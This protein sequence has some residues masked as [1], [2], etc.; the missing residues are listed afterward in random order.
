MKLTTAAV[1]LDQIPGNILAEVPVV[2]VKANVPLTLRIMM[3]HKFALV[4]TGD[5]PVSWRA[6]SLLC[7]YGKGKFVAKDSEDDFTDAELSYH[8]K[9]SQSLVLYN[10]VLQKLEDVLAER[11]KTHPDACVAYHQMEPGEGNEKFG[12]SRKNF[13]AFVPTGG[14]PV[15]PKESETDPD[16]DTPTAL[17]ASAASMV[18]WRSWT[19][20]DT[21]TVWSVTWKALGLMPVRPQVVLLVDGVLEAGMGLTF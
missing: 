5:V 21:D 2:S 9:G 11:Q 15:I 4:N 17:Q 20:A 19:T 8:L 6:G 13:V 7:A 14:K 1:P 3:Q 10:G 12:L 16:D 18:P